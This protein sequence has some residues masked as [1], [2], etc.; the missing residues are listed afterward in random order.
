MNVGFRYSWF[1][2]LRQQRLHSPVFC[3]PLDCEETLPLHS[4]IETV[5][6]LC[7][8]PVCWSCMLGRKCGFPGEPGKQQGLGRQ[9]LSSSTVFC[10][11]HPG[12]VWLCLSRAELWAENLVDKVGGHNL[13]AQRSKWR[14]QERCELPTCPLAQQAL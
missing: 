2:H 11:D 8:A 4:H 12:R 10:P 13:R 14:G 9:N 6:I 1:Q 5:P 3:S 7:A